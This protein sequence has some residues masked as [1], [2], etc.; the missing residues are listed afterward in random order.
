MAGALHQ[1]PEVKQN[2]MFNEKVVPTMSKEK[3]KFL[4][5]FSIIVKGTW[6]LLVLYVTNVSNFSD[7][8]SEWNDPTHMYN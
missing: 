4:K 3:G 8:R 1:R 2:K 6:N 7:R 5:V